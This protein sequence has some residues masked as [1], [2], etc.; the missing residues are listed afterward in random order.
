MQEEEQ[1]SM[2]QPE[3]PQ[4]AAPPEV[5]PQRKWPAG[6]LPGT[7]TKPAAAT[8]S[9][10]P[11][12]SHTPPQ[13]PVPPQVQPPVSGY[14]PPQMPAAPQIQQ[15]NPGYI[16]PG[17]PVPPYVQQPNPGFVPPRNPVPPQ[18]QQ[19]AQ[20][21][22]PPQNPIPPQPHMGQPV[23]GW[24][25]QP[26]ESMNWYQNQQPHYGNWQIPPQVPPQTPEKPPKT[27]AQKDRRA[28]FWLK[29]VAGLMA[30]LL[31]YFI[32]SDIVAFRRGDTKAV[33]TTSQTTTTV[34]E[35]DTNVVIQQQDKPDLDT[36]E[37]NVDENGA[38]TVEGVAAAVRPSIVEIY[39]YGDAN[40]AILS[41]T[42]SGIILS[43]D[44]YIITN[45][46]VLTNGKS[47]RVITSDEK[48]YAA[49]VVGSDAKTDLAVIHIDATGLPAATMGNSDEVV[50]GE[51]VVAIGNPAGLTGSVTNGIVSGLNRKIRS[52]ATG[53]DM[54]CIQTNAAISPGNSG[55]A[56]VNMYGQV[57][58]IT[59]SKYVSSSYE[60]LGF[61]ITINEVLPIVEDLIENGHVSGRVRVGITF[62]SL[63]IEQVQ[64]GFAEEIGMDD[65]PD[66]F[67]GIW[68]TEIASECDI[69]NTELQIN[70]VIV[71]VQGEAVSDYDSLCAAI[72][73]LKAGDEM[74][75]RCRRYHADG[76]F[77]E[78]TIRC[79]LME[80]TSGNY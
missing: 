43:E 64:L 50:L 35:P 18:F 1:K 53:Y 56:L 42:G 55:G 40:S 4:T 77:E 2:T 9:Q 21:F 80:D 52:D 51:A 32:G 16:P 78:F 19:P 65:I 28:A 59:S 62:I 17:N 73:D 8:P 71:S 6:T 36:S 48:E 68:I 30:A 45:A 41:G 23:H 15:P 14:V 66:D 33:Q 49:Q 27:A 11:A 67:S 54:N 31:L 60:G 58:G 12:P 34:D 7:G 37:E 38:Y 76:T 13:Q 5:P 25:P 69:A 46:H 72:A 47:F 70:D 79:K 57:I 24:E 26:Q 74:E 10:E 63:E 44:G 22:V 3:L 75:A 20:G 39:T 61:A 29:I